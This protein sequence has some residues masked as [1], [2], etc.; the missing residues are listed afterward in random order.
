[1]LSSST[2]P[3]S[4]TA[5][6]RYYGQTVHP[7][8]GK[9]RDASAWWIPT[10]F[11]HRVSKFKVESWAQR[12][13]Q[14]RVALRVPK[15]IYSHEYV[16]PTVGLVDMTPYVGS[17]RG[18]VDAAARGDGDGGGDG[19][20]AVLSSFET[21]MPTAAA[22]AATAEAA[23]DAVETAASKAMRVR[24]VMFEVPVRP[25][26]RVNAAARLPKS[27]GAAVDSVE[28]L[29][30][31]DAAALIEASLQALTAT[32][33]ADGAGNSRT[34]PFKLFKLWWEDK[35]Q[36]GAA[37]DRKVM[38]KAWAVL[39]GATKG[40]FIDYFRKMQSKEG[41]AG[42]TSRP[43]QEVSA[44]LIAT[45]S[46]AIVPPPV[47]VNAAAPLPTAEAP[48]PV[49]SHA[50]PP[51]VSAVQSLTWSQI[52]TKF[53]LVTYAHPTHPA[54]PTVKY[55]HLT[56]PMHLIVKSRLVFSVLQDTDQCSV[57]AAHAIQRNWVGW[58]P[59]SVPPKPY[60][61]APKP[62]VLMWAQYGRPFSHSFRPM[63]PP[64]AVLSRH[65]VR[66]EGEVLSKRQHGKTLFLDV[67]PAE[68]RSGG[69]AQLVYNCKWAA[70][71][72]E[73]A[74]FVERVQVGDKVCGKLGLI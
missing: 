52:R 47:Q 59:I 58:Q 26:P 27:V 50:A 19:D 65:M 49:P 25:R 20:G 68:H 72:E 61:L 11:N 67:S 18:G 48:A 2:S 51:E 74:T 43:T 38:V 42:S 66:V 40:V 36:E 30:P 56:H 24:G 4:P 46:T 22:A 34:S 3:T 8:F 5:L 71:Q 64:G 13:Q 41:A 54:H 44:A 7:T 21:T 9:Y 69:I 15:F 10:D 12:K 62:Y 32:A 14:V 35:Q 28:Q 1:M 33:G 39:D 53:M 73:V 17:R 6:P 31:Q 45:P 63:S 16:G 60:V 29:S 57:R 37:V 70:S 55:I 23:F